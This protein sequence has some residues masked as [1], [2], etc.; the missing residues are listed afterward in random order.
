MD[1]NSRIADTLDKAADL[2]ESE[3]VDWCQGAYV[4]NY[5]DP[6]PVRLSVCASQA[7]RM[8]C[9]E[10]LVWRGQE[11]GEAPAA[12][13]PA[14]AGM[15]FS[16]FKAATTSLGLV[17]PDTSPVN[18]EGNLITWNDQTAGRYILQE[19]RTKQDVIDLFKNKAKELRNQS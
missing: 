15:D 16:L 1:L 6:E 12:W 8:A 9:G 5:S 10:K 3:T 19:R 7:L 17:D 2:Y 14:R 11:A 13:V 4:E 18:G